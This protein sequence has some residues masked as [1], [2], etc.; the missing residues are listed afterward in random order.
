MRTTLEKINIS[1][2]GLNYVIKNKLEFY[3]KTEKKIKK[4]TRTEV[5]IAK[6]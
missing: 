4:K 3:K 1:Q 6:Y 5:K 2:I